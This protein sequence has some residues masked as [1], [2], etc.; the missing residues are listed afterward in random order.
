MVINPSLLEIHRVLIAAN[1]FVFAQKLKP[2]QHTE[3][4]HRYL[5]IIKIDIV[6]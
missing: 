5:R 4:D 2:A 6:V 1:F 3:I